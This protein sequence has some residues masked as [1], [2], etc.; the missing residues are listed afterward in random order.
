[1][2]SEVH[3]SRKGFTLIELVMVM[4]IVAVLSVVGS[5]LLIYLVQNSIII[6]NQLNTNMVASQ[7]LDSMI[8][9][10]SNARGLRSSRSITAIGDNQLTFNSQD[11]QSITWRLDTVA[12]K[13]YRSIDGGAEALIPYYAVTGVN[14]AGESSKLFTYFD[15]SENTASLPADVRRIRIDLIAMT[16]SGSFDDWQGRSDVATSIAVH[17]LE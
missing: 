5:S 10:D 2:I 6:P 13:L 16:G 17:K 12:N 8:E 4:L 9:G 7:A 3:I 15:A 1:M 11:G 14:L